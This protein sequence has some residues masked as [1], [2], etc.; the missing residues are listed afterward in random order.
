M[1]K[2]KKSTQVNPNHTPNFDTFPL[3]E[4]DQQEKRSKVSIPSVTSVKEVKDW[5]DFKEM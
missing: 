5:V 2:K 4:A 3:M 1:K